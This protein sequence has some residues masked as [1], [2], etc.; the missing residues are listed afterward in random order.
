M[1]L[2]RVKA[3]PCAATWGP[4]AWGAAVAPARK[5]ERRE[6]DSLVMA[7]GIL[8]T[9]LGEREKDKALQTPERNPRDCFLGPFLWVCRGCGEERYLLAVRSLKIFIAIYYVTLGCY[10]SKQLGC[11]SWKRRSGNQP[12][13]MSE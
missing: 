5:R 3:E 12:I 11:P 6:Q 1:Q 8:Y 7:G 9:E 13:D 2:R 10:L 4:R